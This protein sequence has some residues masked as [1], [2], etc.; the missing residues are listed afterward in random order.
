MQLL[1]PPSETKRDG[2]VDGS[3]LRLGA[4]SFPALRAP[5]RAAL[6]ALRELSADP[7]AAAV[8]LGLGPTQGAEL[9]RNRRVERSPV[10][11]AI[12]RYTGVLYDGIGLDGLD[13]AS[14]AYGDRTL[15]IHSA[16]FGVLRAGDPI[17]AYR[18]SHDSRL[19]GL[20]LP[21]H[22]R[23]P[24]SAV[25]GELQATEPVLDLRSSSYVG[26]G[27]APTAA[28]TLRVVRDGAAGRRVAISHDNKRFKGALVGALL[29]S[30]PTLD[31]I[32]DL[33]AWGASAGFVLQPAGDGRLDL[34]V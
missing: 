14:R 11:P 24:V 12:E 7:V 22:W 13:A 18:V 19:P 26:L 29:R 17:P 4:L 1:L 6:H 34:V 10:L 3:H 27:P 9:E 21:A 28:T 16:L 8:A 23:S 2:G 15:L 25:L 31:A 5:R 20:R 33:I 32:D 30:Q